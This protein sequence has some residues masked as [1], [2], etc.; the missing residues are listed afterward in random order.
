MKYVIV[1]TGGRS[2]M[3]TEAFV[4]KYKESSQIAA[5]CD[6]NAGR[7]DIAVK[8]LK[9]AFPNIKAYSHD[10]FDEM[11]KIHKPDCVIVTTRDCDHDD[12]ICRSLEAGC[13]AITE[14]PMTEMKIA[15]SESSIR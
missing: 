5:V 6:S 14:K 2:M 7:L 10:K 11:I 8:K 9:E 15:A 12:Y 4:E 13:D 1:G 3:F